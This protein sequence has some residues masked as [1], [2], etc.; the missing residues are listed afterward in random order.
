MAME[1]AKAQKYTA[2]VSDKYYLTENQKFLYIKLELI[3]PDRISYLAGQYVSVLVGEQGERRS[4]S[5]ASLSD[6]NHGFHLLAE[7]IEGGKGSTF[8]QKIEPGTEVEVLAPLGR[9]IVQEE[10]RANKLLFVATGSGIVPIW[11]MINDLLINKR[12]KRPIRLHWGM[13][14]ENDLFWMDNLERLTEE[15]PNFVFDIVLSKPREDWE[16][17]SGHVQDCLGRDF[18]GDG[19]EEWEGYVCGNPQMVE[20]VSELLKNLKMPAEQI[21]HEKFA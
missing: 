11:S 4:Y 2:R 17:C 7:I 3:E 18:G 8:W 5:I 10:S 14:E 13:R 19:L 1:F 15:H 12:D 21:Y 9:F 6:D 16:L 20:Q